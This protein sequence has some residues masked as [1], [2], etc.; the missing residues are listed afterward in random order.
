MRALV[1]CVV[2]A[3]SAVAAPTAGSH[4]VGGVP[5]PPQPGTL[6]A[7]QDELSA[8][9]GTN[10]AGRYSA[11]YDPRTRTLRW[12]IDYKDTTGPATAVR[13]R[14][15]IGSRTMARTLC[16][17]CKSV[18]RTGRKGPYQSVSGVIRNP[19]RDVVLLAT[20][21]LFSSRSQVVLATADHPLGELYGQ[22]PEPP[23][24]GTGGGR[25]C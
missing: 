15:R 16:S 8:V 10:G 7:H 22:L 23:A 4:L 9:A 17:H 2:V 1:G 20:P 6:E 19:S 18:T 24:T 14:A 11:T 25:C 13:V 3:I 21:P 12:R 5:A